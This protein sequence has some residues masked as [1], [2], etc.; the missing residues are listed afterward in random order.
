V[1]FSK[2]TPIGYDSVATKD[3]DFDVGIAD[4]NGKEHGVALWLAQ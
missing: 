1:P 4:V 3:A 2:H